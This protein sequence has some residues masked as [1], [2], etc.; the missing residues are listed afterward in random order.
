MTTAPIT[1]GPCDPR[2]RLKKKGGG[3]ALPVLPVGDGGHA[4]PHSRMGKWRAAVL[5]LIHVIIIGHIIQWWY[6]GMSDGTRETLSPVEPSESMFTLETGRINA[7]FIM[8]AL[9]IL[10][11]LVL[12]RFFCGW[13]CHIVAVQDFCAWIMK[14]FGIHPKPWRSRLLLWVPLGLALYMFVWPTFRREVLYRWLGEKMPDWMGK[15]YPLRGFEHHY[16]VENFWAT[17]P[18]WYVAV[19]TFLICGFAT[20]YFM[21]AKAFCTYGCPYGGF[22]SPIDRLAPGRIR[23]TDD[24]HHCGHCTSVCTSNVRVHEEVRDYGM[25]VDPG[26][27]KCLDCVSACPNGALYWG[28]GKPAVFAGP[29]PGAQISDAREKRRKRYDLSLGEELVIAAVFLLFLFGFRGMYFNFFGADFTIPLLMAVGMSALGCFAV[30]KLWRMTRDVNVRAP[31]WQ[32]KLSGRVRPAGWAFA[33]GA[34]LWTALAVQGA[35]MGYGEVRGGVLYGR[36]SSLPRLANDV[37]YSPGY[38]PA[39]EDQAAARKAIALLSLAGPTSDGGVGFY[40]RWLTRAKLVYLH[41]VA[42]D[43]ESSE[44]E[45]IQTVRQAPE[46]GEYVDGLLVLAQARNKPLSD[47]EATLRGLYREHPQSEPIRHALAQLLLARQRG[48]EAVELYDAALKLTPRDTRVILSAA[49]VNMMQGRAQRA[50]E[51]LEQGI[52]RMPKSPALNGMLAEVFVMSERPADALRQAR[53]A[54]ELQPGFEQYKV[55]A[56]AHDLNHDPAGMLEALTKAAALPDLD[57]DQLETAAQLFEA[58]GRSDDAKVARAR[59]EKLRG[60]SP[61]PNRPTGEK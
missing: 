39:P 22:F 50:V 28:F 27:M 2:N 25:V 53:H 45:L 19:P 41:A 32:L 20:V 43:L 36:L 48:P 11:T 4:K 44:R 60:S 31:Y 38:K 57:T 40:R 51:I 6:S 61:N 9:A 58:V 46:N 15:V 56:L 30:H 24:C 16:V 59:A 26:C 17:F 21:G 29:R 8:F 34:I 35:V 54:V 37:I 42:G 10:A 23:V 52:E 3:I 1:S 47:L 7:G 33:L 49:Q 55:L 14:K 18:P 12:G 5:I 13:A